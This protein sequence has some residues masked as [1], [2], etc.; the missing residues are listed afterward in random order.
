MQNFILHSNN[1]SDSNS[2]DLVLAASRVLNGYVC[3][4]IHSARV[5]HDFLFVSYAHSQSIIFNDAL[6][7]REHEPLSAAAMVI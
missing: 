2:S 5:G 7:A 4:E 6:L 1:S 3:D